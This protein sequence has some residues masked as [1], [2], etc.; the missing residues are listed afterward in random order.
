MA[1][2]ASLSACQ[3]GEAHQRATA[4]PPVPVHV[5][6]VETRA[7]AAPV[8]GVGVLAAKEEVSL[9][10]KVGGVVERIRVESGQ[11][12]RAG[13]VLAELAQVEID[14]DV[15]KAKHGRDKAER[16]LARATSLYRD[17]VATLEQVQNATTAVEMAVSNVHIA[18]F[19]R[20]YAAIRAPF[21]GTVLKRSVEANQLVAPGVTVVV[22]RNERSGL[23][24]RVG[25]PDRDAV[26]V[27][28]GD[29]AIAR[30]DAWPGVRFAAR[31]L[32]VAAGATAGTGTYEAELLVEPA[33][34][35]LASGLIGEGV[36]RARAARRFAYVPVAA[37]LEADGDSASVYVLDPTGRSARRRRVQ[38]AF[39]EGSRVAIAAGIGASDRVVT[40]GNTRI[41]DGSR[42][43]VLMPAEGRTGAFLDG[44]VS[45]P[46]A[47]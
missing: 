3:R 12:V 39:L 42:V 38:V 6:A 5:A 4:A 22:V 33:G 37:L 23:V 11:R 32:R 2:I 34:H 15:D 16:D 9:A 7:G 43:R 20:R 41:I 13:E 14:A 25:L 21:D 24:L 35:V 10:F 27:A 17:S 26:R 31:V 19:N 47:P 36:I 29:G 45:A 30:F 40:D 1:A 18:E 46:A 8:L 28:A 44:R